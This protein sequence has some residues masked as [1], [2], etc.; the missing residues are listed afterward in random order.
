MMEQ[1]AYRG[2]LWKVFGMEQFMHGMWEH[3][4]VKRAWAKAVL[5]DAEK[6]KQQGIQV[7]WQLDTPFKEVLEQIKKS[8]DMS[9][10][11]YLMRRAC[12]AGKSGDWE[13][14][15]EAHRDRG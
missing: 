13:G 8:S 2:K 1:K 15:K 10:N 4:T 11:A 12:C 7:K 14:Y 5:A 6:E 3:F 9:C